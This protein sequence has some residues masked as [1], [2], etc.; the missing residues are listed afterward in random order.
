VDT[1]KATGVD[2]VEVDPSGPRVVIIGP[3]QE[4][5]DAARELLEFVTVRV[6][7]KPEQVRRRGRR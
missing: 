1:Q 7:V 5:V 3:T 6:D 4:A 2:R